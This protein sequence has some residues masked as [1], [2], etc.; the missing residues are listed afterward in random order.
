MPEEMAMVPDLAARWSS[1]LDLLEANRF[2]VREIVQPGATAEEIAAL[3][4]AVGLRL[5]DEIRTLYALGNG[6][7]MRPTLG[8]IRE[9]RAAP[10]PPAA[11]PLFGFYEFLDTEGAAKAWTL[12]KS[13]ADEQGPDGMADMASPSSSPSQ[14]R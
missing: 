10:L 6:Q 11:V 3:E 8:M 12:W 13:I 2:T 4:A 1:W 7:R 5:T 14:A 9:G